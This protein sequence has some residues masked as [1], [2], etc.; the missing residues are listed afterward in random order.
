MAEKGQPGR[1]TFPRPMVRHPGLE[2]SF[3]GLKTFAA[4]TAREHTLDE[5]T[6]A[7]IAWAFQDAVIDTLT[8]KTLRALKQTGLKKLVVAGGVSANQSLR[9]R[10]QETAKE[11]RFEVFYARPEFCVDNGAMVAY[12]GYQKLLQGEQEE[13]AI[14]VRPRWAIA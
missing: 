11:K 7:D 1:F 12:C 5:Q 3:S 8:I 13:L 4:N 6:K 14:K 9:E 10:L 2:F